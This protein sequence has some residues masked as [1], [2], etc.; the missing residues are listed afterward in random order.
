[1]TRDLK[2]LR[3]LWRTWIINWYS[4]FYHSVLRD[5]E[6]QVLWMLRVIYQEWLTCRYGICNMEPWLS[7]SRFFFFIAIS[8]ITLHTKITYHS[9]FC[10]LLTLFLVWEQVIK[11]SI[12]HVLAYFRDSGKQNFYIHDTLCRFHTQIPR[13]C[14][15]ARLLI[16]TVLNER[17]NKGESPLEFR[18]LS[19]VFYDE[20]LAN[21]SILFCRKMCHAI[22]LIWCKFSIKVG[23]KI[24]QSSWQILPATSPY[25]KPC[26]RGFP[27]RT[28]SA[29][30]AATILGTVASEKEHL[31]AKFS[32]IVQLVR[33][34][35]D[36]CSPNGR[37][38]QEGFLVLSLSKMN[39]TA[40]LH[41]CLLHL[42]LCSFIY[43]YMY[44]PEQ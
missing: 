44:F 2:V 34:F 19:F 22:R 4:W 33:V 8:Y 30:Q 43:M 25:W 31:V 38:H 3:D 36:Q 37:S 14:V 29:L 17:R 40:I 13:L 1:M 9:R 18:Q 27:L 12:L 16:A 6:R 21:P 35:H 28:E 26:M 15:K 24:M 11:K 41:I 20:M 39:S 5:F 7:H 32:E 10:F 23:S 42:F